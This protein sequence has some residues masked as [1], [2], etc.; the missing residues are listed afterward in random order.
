MLCVCVCGGFFI[1]YANNL[2]TYRTYVLYTERGWGGPREF[3]GGAARCKPHFIRDATAYIGFSTET[4]KKVRDESERDTEIE[5]ER[6]RESDSVIV[7]EWE[8]E[9]IEERVL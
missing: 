9:K 5:R 2:I 4:N 8:K 6:E 3:G 7:S 1:N